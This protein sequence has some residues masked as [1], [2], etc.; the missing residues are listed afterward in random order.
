MKKDCL[1]NGR[2]ISIWVCLSCIPSN[3]LYLIGILE[4]F[5]IKIERS[6]V[7]FPVGRVFEKK[8]DYLVRWTTLCRSREDGVGVS[9]SVSCRTL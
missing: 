6:E 4:D 7:R 3:I 2:E 1:F 8:M 5:E 9:D